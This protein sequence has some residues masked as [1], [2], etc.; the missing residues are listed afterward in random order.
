MCGGVPVP[1]AVKLR[2]T[3]PLVTAEIV[4]QD[5]SLAGV[6]GPVIHTLIGSLRGRSQ[7]TFGVVG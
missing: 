1:L 2:I 3:A 7:V 4:C 5:W 6:K